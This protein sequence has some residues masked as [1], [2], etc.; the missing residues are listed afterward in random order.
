MFT[1]G[2]L[3][4]SSFILVLLRGGEKLKKWLNFHVNDKIIDNFLKKFKS[5]FLG[6]FFGKNIEE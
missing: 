5:S 6:P 1:S 3:S 4:V 2:C